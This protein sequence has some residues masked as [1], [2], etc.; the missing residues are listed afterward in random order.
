MVLI[1]LFHIDPQKLSHTSWKHAL[2]TLPILFICFGYQNL[3]PTLVDYLKRDINAL[4]K[5]IVFGNLIPLCFYLIWNLI[6][7]GLAP[8]E[9]SEN[10][11][12]VSDLLQQATQTTFILFLS[13]AFSF[14]ALTTSFIAV[15]MSFVDFF[16]DGLQ[17]LQFRSELLN[18]GIVLF[19][20]F[21]PPLV[22]CF[23]YPHI[24]LKALDFAG[25]GRR[26]SSIW[27]SPRFICL[28]W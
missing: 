5:V 13:E 12:M 27:S 4:R 1:G 15:G 19:L 17:H 10:A 24:F 20:V 6:I 21:F 26:R 16:S 23:L 22:L 9:F 2:A 28:V 7:L 18:R 3:V 11:L 25:G 14:F 8:V